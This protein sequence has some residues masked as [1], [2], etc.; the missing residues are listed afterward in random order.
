MNDATEGLKTYSGGAERMT[1]VLKDMVGI[2][3]PERAYG[4]PVTAGEYTV[5]PATE[6]MASMG[7]GYGGGSGPCAKGAAERERQEAQAT[8]EGGGG[9]GGGMCFS[10]AVA[11]IAIGPN[12]VAVKPVLDATK[13]ALALA[14]AVGSMLLLTARMAKRVKSTG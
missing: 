1:G 11:V 9:G 2:A 13:I 7:V 10:R 8:G 12:G 14:T 4:Q 3:K 5:I 6:V